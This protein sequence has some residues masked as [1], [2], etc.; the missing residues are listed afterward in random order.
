MPPNGFSIKPLK[1]KLLAG[2]QK[3]SEGSWLV[4]YYIGNLDPPCQTLAV[5]RVYEPLAVVSLFYLWIVTLR[6]PSEIRAGL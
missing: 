1:V 6:F 5:L 3:A 2:E 4:T